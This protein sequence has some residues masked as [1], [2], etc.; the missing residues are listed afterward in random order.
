ML[1]FEFLLP[2]EDAVVSPK[3]RWENYLP[4]PLLESQAHEHQKKGFYFHLFL[5]RRL[6]HIIVQFSSQLAHRYLC[7]ANEKILRGKKQSSVRVGSLV[8]STI[9][10]QE[11]C[12]LGRTPYGKVQSLKGK[13]KCEGD[14]SK[15]P[16]SPNVSD[17]WRLTVR[18][19]HCRELQRRGCWSAC[20]E[21]LGAQPRPPVCVDTNTMHT[22]RFH[23]NVLRSWKDA[24]DGG[25]GI[26]L[27]AAAK[28]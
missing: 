18:R 17:E 8:S 27:R 25:W 6:T 21:H 15:C 26:N 1:Y 3:I 2:N 11:G 22:Q 10:S 24:G 23:S 14:G 13:K 12:C 16:C 5:L 9:V 28:I 20:Q 4:T 7:C 19:T